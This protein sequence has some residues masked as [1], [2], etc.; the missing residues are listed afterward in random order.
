VEGD[1]S[2]G[3]EALESDQPGGLL[4]IQIDVERDRLPD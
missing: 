1:R 3:Q 4:L 2:L